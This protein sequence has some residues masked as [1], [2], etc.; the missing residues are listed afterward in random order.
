VSVTDL[1]DP[2]EIIRIPGRE[3]T[4]TREQK[5]AELDMLLA[6]LE[7]VRLALA[8]PL[9]LDEESIAGAERARRRP[10]LLTW[11]ARRVRE[12]LSALAPGATHARK[13]KR[14]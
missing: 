5:L 4:G 9:S 13:R 1:G 10:G 8:E 6:Q 2:R 12:T 14:W 11:P 3:L 7:L